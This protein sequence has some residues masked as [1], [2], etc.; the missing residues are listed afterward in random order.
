[1]LEK[2]GFVG[3]LLLTLSAPADVPDDPSHESIAKQ[4][5][6]SNAPVGLSDMTVRTSAAANQN[7]TPMRLERWDGSKS[8]QF[9]GTLNANSE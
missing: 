2:C 8:Q 9:G 3:S 4:A 7:S 6:S 5:K 1:M